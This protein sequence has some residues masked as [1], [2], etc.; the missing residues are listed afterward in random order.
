MIRV[1]DEDGDDVILPPGR[2]WIS[3]F[4][5]HRTITWE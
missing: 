4:P 3:V 1:V 2:V 5:D